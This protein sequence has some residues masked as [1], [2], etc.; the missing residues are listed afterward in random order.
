[1][2]WSHHWERNTELPKEQ[3]AEAVADCENVLQ[4]IDVS[5]GG[6][7]GTGKPV[8][9]EEHVVFNG[10]EGSGCEPFE[11]ARVEFDR[12]GRDKV[13]SSCKTEQTPYD[14]CVQV[15]LVI[16]KHHLADAI[17]VGSDGTNRD[18]EESRRICQECLGYGMDFKLEEESDDA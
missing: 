1:M 3:F 4:T 12:R 14:I 2:G 8:F 13:F 10:T 7:D 18:W 9:S 15:S 6:F 17:G 16:L 11:I 5:L